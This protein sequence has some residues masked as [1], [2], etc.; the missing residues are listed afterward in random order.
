MRGWCISF[1]ILYPYPSLRYIEAKLISYSQISYHQHSRS[2]Q[3]FK[4]LY[5][6]KVSAAR[7]QAFINVGVIFSEKPFYQQSLY[8]L[9]TK[10]TIK[11]REC[12]T[13]TSS[14]LHIFKQNPGC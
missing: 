10:T 4:Y 1:C 11:T 7:P 8:R 3:R 5:T 12:L 2:I 6:R 9:Y 14:A 13:S